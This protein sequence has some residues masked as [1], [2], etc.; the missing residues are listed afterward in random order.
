MLPW[1]LRRMPKTNFLLYILLALLHFLIVHHLP[2]NGCE[3]PKCQRRLNLDTSNANCLPFAVTPY[4]PSYRH[5][6]ITRPRYKRRNYE[7][8]SNRVREG[9]VFA[10]NDADQENESTHSET[11]HSSQ[12]TAK[13]WTQTW[14][15]SNIRRRKEKDTNTMDIPSWWYDM[16]ALVCI[17]FNRLHYGYFHL[18]CY[19]YCYRVI[20]QNW[21]W[22][23]SA[24]DHHFDSAPSSYEV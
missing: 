7:C 15:L 2:E 16:V 18:F 21:F 23:A 17:H 10:E 5:P 4:S 13:Y 22:L 14:Q 9:Q 11:P 12:L 6:N 8:N 3:I 20:E 24:F 1:Q 19:C